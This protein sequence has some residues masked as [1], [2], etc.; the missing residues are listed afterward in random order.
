[1]KF[2]NIS[3]PFSLAF[4]AALYYLN[5][6]KFYLFIILIYYYISRSLIFMKMLDFLSQNNF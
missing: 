3:S 5:Y 1:M 2:K 4:F 6:K